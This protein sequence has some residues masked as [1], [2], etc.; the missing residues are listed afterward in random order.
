MHLRVR[1]S[2]IPRLAGAAAIIWVCGVASAWAGGGGEDAG[3]VQTFLNTIC[4]NL[5]FAPGSC[6]QLPTITQGVLEIAGLGY[7][8]PEAIRR[9]QNIP[10]GSVF[11]GNAPPVPATP[12]VPVSLPLTPLAFSNLGLTP[13]AFVSPGNGRDRED[14]QDREDSKTASKSNGFAPV[15]QL[16]DPEANSFFYA[17][18]TYG[19]VG[20]NPQPQT[21]NLFY[22]DLSR[23]NKVF[24]KG[25]LVAKISVPLVVYDSNAC[26]TKPPAGCK[27]TEVMTILEVRATCTGGASNCLTAYAIADFSAFGTSKCSS[28]SADQRCAAADLGISFALVFGSSPTSD[29]PHAIFEVQVPLIVTVANDPVH[30]SFFSPQANLI[31]TP[32][33]GT[34]DLGSPLAFLPGKSI[35]VATYPAPMTV[36]GA[37]TANFGFCASLP[38]N[39]NGLHPAVA[40]FLDIATDGETLISAPLGESSNP[41]LQCPF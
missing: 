12:L 40:A 37:T 30:F 25:Q 11:A 27:E 5:G 31:G 17:A 1:Y 13:L 22:H 32:T 23:T 3:N 36:T 8:R 15:T 6:P 33:F 35:G 16:Y 41:G 28:L 29:H 26:M 9:S 7:A 34:E 20:G 38:G 14:S 4:G 39:G 2:K 21:L 24:V 19:N 18:T 10:P